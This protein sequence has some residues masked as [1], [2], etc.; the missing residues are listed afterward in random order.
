MSIII[1]WWF[2]LTSQSRGSWSVRLQHQEGLEEESSLKSGAG[3]ITQMSETS[4]LPKGRCLC[5]ACV[6][7]SPC[8]S[9]KK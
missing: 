3:I 1:L 8:S 4:W 5:H 7:W 6:P 9:A 2:L